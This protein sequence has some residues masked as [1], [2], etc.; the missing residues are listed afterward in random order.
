MGVDGGGV[1]IDGAV[2]ERDGAVGFRDGELKRFGILGA[3]GA[4][5]LDGERVSGGG[6]AAREVAVGERQG[7]DGVTGVEGIG[8]GAED[9]DVVEDVGG[10]DGNFY[11]AGRGV[12]TAEQ[13]A[14]LASIAK[15]AEDVSGGEQVAVAIDEE[16][17]AV[18]D[19]V[20]A[21]AGGGVVELVDD[22]ADGGGDGGGCC[23]RDGLRD[24]CSG[25]RLRT[26]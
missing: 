18:K 3:G 6:P 12:G 14:R 11:E 9:G 15:F 16:G 2:G 7:G 17:V 10:D 26:R 1:E 4:Q 8:R 22:G 25:R 23:W 24:F 19:V 5:G 20:V 13:D 21:V